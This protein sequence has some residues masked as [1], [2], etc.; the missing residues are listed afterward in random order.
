VVTIWQ[1]S[2]FQPG[3]GGSSEVVE[4]SRQVPADTKDSHTYEC[5]LTNQI[6]KAR[7]LLLALLPVY[8]NPLT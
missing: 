7:R 3:G 5:R 2:Y 4:G 1:D 8:L 6:E